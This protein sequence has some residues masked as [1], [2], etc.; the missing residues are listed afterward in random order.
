MIKKIKKQ[1]SG[2]LVT[3][4]SDEVLTIPEGYSGW[5]EPHIDSY[6]GVIEPEFTELELQ[7]SNLETQIQ[8]SKQYLADTAWY[9]ERLNDP[10]SGKAIPDDVLAKR[11]EARENIN[12]AEILLSELKGE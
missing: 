4:N 3:L 7:I 12:S 9:I 6:D 11:A 10:S 8:Q 5:L 2:L 1:K